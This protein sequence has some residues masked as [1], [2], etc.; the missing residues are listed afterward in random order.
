MTVLDRFHRFRP[1]IEGLVDRRLPARVPVSPTYA[2]VEVIN[3][4]NLRCVM[5][6]ISE[7]TAA[8]KRKVLDLEGFTEIVRQMPA[9][10][11]VDLQG[12]G[13]PLLNPHLEEIIRWCNERSM[14]VGFVTNGL[15]FD[16]ERMESV[17]RAGPSF[18]IVSV[19][20]VDPETFAQIRPGADINA[21]LANIRELLRTRRR[22]G[23]DAPHIGIMS[24][25]MKHSLG[26]L[27]AVVEAA[28]D[29]GV[30]G[31]TIKGVNTRPNPEVGGG[32]IDDALAKIREAGERHPDLALTIAVE[33]ARDRLSCRWPWT[34]AYV[35]VEGELTPCCNCPDARH[36]SFG[37]VHERSFSA[38]WNGRAYR[39]FRRELRDG[40][41]DICRDCPDY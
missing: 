18:M 1:R 38:L 19:D 4:C 31:L 13:E 25:A 37:N 26:G 9:L 2:Q 30:D 6:S 11:R 8:R 21:L 39:A 10:R 7:L 12:I 14:E 29:L 16:S 35:T 24:V 3:R 5:C 41:P 22:L 33:N 17:L 28:A 32:G 20:S 36:V 40:M 34:S 27:P 15:L 23:L